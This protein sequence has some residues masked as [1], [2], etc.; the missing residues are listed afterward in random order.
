M[1]HLK[2]YLITALLL[3]MSISAINGQEKKVNLLAEFSM[4][5]ESYKNKDFEGAEPHGWIVLDTDPSKFLQYRPFKK[6]EEVLK[7]DYDSLATTDAEKDSVAKKAIKLYD[8]AI[9]VGAK[10]PEY[11]IM[12]KAYVTEQW[13]DAT[14]EEK[15]AAYITALEKVPN[16]DPYYK[17]RLGLLYAKNAT[18]ENGYKLKA[19]QIYMKLAEE[20]PENE[21]WNRRIQELADDMDQL[22]EFMKKSWDLD[23]G[24]SEKAWKYAEMC[25]KADEYEKAVEPLELLVKKSPDVVTYWKKLTTVYKNIDRPDDAIKAYKTLINLD[26]GN[27]ENYYN[28]AVIYNNLNQLS[29]A[30]SYLQKASKASKEPWDVPLYVEAQLYEKAASQSGSFKFMDKCVYQLASDTYARAARIG[31]SSSSAASERV[32]TLK[33]TVPQKEDY[34]FRGYKVGDKIKIEGPTYGWIKRSIT[35]R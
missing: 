4:F 18:E 15:I 25:I 19:L 34:F 35:V 6:M 9:E 7:W 8:R 10:N 28:L 21:T 31:G 27:K 12:R 16:A 33:K 1:K 17:D 22:L 13:S 24:N 32:R 29:V 14:P 26:T 11:F 5:Y 23:K 2:L 30:R 3:L 20:D